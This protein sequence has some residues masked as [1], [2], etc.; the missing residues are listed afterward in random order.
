[1]PAAAQLVVLGCQRLQLQQL[2]Q[3]QQQAAWLLALTIV[4]WSS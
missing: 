1:L 2:Q 4:P 3:E